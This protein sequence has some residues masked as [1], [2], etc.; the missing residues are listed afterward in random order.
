MVIFC[1]S[2]RFVDN[3]FQNFFSQVRELNFYQE[4]DLTYFNQEMTSCHIQRV[5]N[6][7]IDK[8][9]YERRKLQVDSFNGCVN[10][11]LLLNVP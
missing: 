5:W 1:F 10:I 4:G 2:P 3:E 7:L 11:A 8:C 9:H 6:E